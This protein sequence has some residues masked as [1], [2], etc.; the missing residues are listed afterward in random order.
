MIYFNNKKYLGQIPLRTIDYTPHS[1]Y[2][3]LY[4]QSCVDDNRL[5]LHVP[6]SFSLEF[7]ISTDGTNWD[8]WTPETGETDN[9]FVSEFA[10]AYDVVFIRATN[11]NTWAG[12]SGSNNCVRFTLDRNFKCGGSVMSLLNKY[13]S[14]KTI[15]STY[16]FAYL[17]SNCANLMTAP[18]LPATALSTYCY[19]RMFED[20]T[21]LKTAPEL[22]C[23]SLTNYCY[24]Y[25]FGNCKSLIKA[26][27]LPATTLATYCYFGMFYGCTNLTTVQS[28]LP[29]TTLAT[30]CY[31][32]MF[33]SCENLTT[34]PL[35]PAKSILGR[36]YANMFEDC[37]KLTNVQSAIPATNIAINGCRYMFHG[38]TSLTTAPK[39]SATTIATQ[40]FQ[41]MFQDCTNLTTAPDI[42]PAKT[43]TGYC[44]NY[45]F[46]GC[47]NL[48]TSPILPASQLTGSYCYQG[49]FRNC[50]KLNYVIVSATTWNSTNASSWLYGVSSTGDFYCPSSLT[51]TSGTNGKPTNW[52]RHNI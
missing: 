34:A 37:T 39:I 28:A 25:M 46:D 29:A 6:N 3:Y 12:S 47:R 51:I 36:S 15:S 20:C 5:C 16:Q 21:S 44:Y 18:E 31:G 45:M 27:E 9:M 26:P 50:A 41:Y 2:N 19:T 38:C 22:P 49:M 10:H 1:E 30:Y 42:L 52:T 23:K 8:Y 17:F 7:D 14:G 32:S 43:L 40:C 4:F 35:L 13:A 11:T 24:Y 48:I 33:K